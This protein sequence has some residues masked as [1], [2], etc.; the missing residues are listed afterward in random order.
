MLPGAEAP[1][2]SGDGG[3][4]SPPL[5]ELEVGA[6]F[7]KDSVLKNNEPAA[8]S[9]AIE[10]GLGPSGSRIAP[11]TRHSVFFGDSEMAQ[12]MAKFD[13]S[14][15]PLGPVENW[16]QSLKTSV[17]LI[18]NSQHPMWIGWGPERTF[19][20]NDA[21]VSVLSAAKHPWALGRP[22][23]EV[24]A[25]IWDVCGPLA[26][27]VFQK[28]EATFVNDVQLFMRRGEGFLEETF[29]S[30]S[31]SPIRD[32][33]GAVAG[34]FCP[35][36]EVTAKNLNARRLA[37]LSELAG[38]SFVEKTTERA[39]AS[40][41]ATL[42]KNTDDIPFFLIYLIEGGKQAV[43]RES[44]RIAIGSPLAAR[45][46]SLEGENGTTNEWSI[47]EVVRAR[48]PKNVSL[49][50]ISFPFLGLAGQPLT[51]A[52]VLPLISRGDDAPVG[53]L[54][55]GVNPTRKLD[56]DHRTFFNL[57]AGQ[58]A[59][60]IANA[61]ASEQ[62][63]KRL[64]ALAE[65]D[66]AKTVFFNNVSHEFR[67]PLTLMLGPV[68]ELLNHASVLTPEDRQ[69]QM[70]VV[71]R[72]C[73]RLLK[74]VNTLL[75]FSRIEAGRIQASYEPVDLCIF[76]TDLASAFRSAM[77]KAGLSF[78]VQC[79][80]LPQ[81]VFV[82]RDMW[83]KIVF[84][85][86][87]NAFKFTLK[88][89]VTLSLVAEGGE[90]VLRVADTGTGIPE[91]EMGNVFKRFHRVHNVQSR[92]HEGTG[93]GLAMVQDLVKLHGGTISVESKFGKGSTFT[94]RLPFGDKHLP[95]ERVGARERSTL[96]S[97]TSGDV[98]VEEAMRWIP[99]GGPGAD[100][101]KALGFAPVREGKLPRI[102]VADD[103]ADMRDY[104]G[105]LL[106]GR[107]ELEMTPDGSDALTAARRKKPDIII[108]DIMMPRM[109]GFALLNAIRQDSDLKTVPVILLSA[110]AGDEARVEGIQEGA[111]D[112]L[113]KPF[114]GRE[115]V[116]RLETH[117]KLAR[118]RD[119]AQEA[120]KRLNKELEQRVEERT[121]SLRAAIAQM[122]EFSYSVSHDL[123]SPV[124]AMHGYAKV[125]IE[126]YGDKLDSEGKD[127]LQ[128]IVQSSTRMDRLIHD[129]LTYT[130]VARQEIHLERI[131]L[132]RFVRGVIEQFPEFA[133]NRA[134]IVIE[135]KLPEAVGH[136][137]S[138]SQVI[139]NLL[140]NAVKFVAPGV[141]P[142]VRIRA[143]LH[144]N[145]VRLWFEDNGIGIKP[146]YQSRLFGM[147]E[148]IHPEG[149]YQGTGIGL[150]IVRKSMERMNGKAGLESDGVHGSKFWIQM[151]AA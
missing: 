28:G 125:V 62:E 8:M 69:L 109:D 42:A 59:T 76:T 24:W 46:A 72:N 11:A 23:S 95:G 66:R 48:E 44:G 37:T 65:L 39:V 9:R 56:A 142:E 106:H 60:A 120:Q 145:S 150:A 29:Y 82:D 26:E 52:Q 58:L 94:V 143:E 12:L 102:V 124:R 88:G 130:R 118:V 103:N 1:V 133:P 19:L 135:G 149:K 116:A 2:V 137:P 7:A 129:V 50:D 74:L 84:N 64:E 71:H 54:V 104:I 136:E 63:R 113:V 45:T 90:A 18:L 38:N 144:G 127:L 75:D 43:L 10:P 126:D 134:K 121:A 108:S 41:A 36:S 79:G 17:N 112:Y 85:L 100:G 67:T 14:R 105:H 99:E 117:L 31:Y 128:R 122:E 101:E 4:V 151:R 98:F 91:S 80:P 123:R 140:H 3:L 61:R 132:D 16:P 138:L 21:Y 81:S 148:R 5:C 86:L 119:E 15:T 141:M 30:F 110:R 47:R 115:L 114:S 73:L 77:E 78:D 87:S 49:R 146:E 53:V 68:E 6:Q 57:I 147:F 40:A 32:E 33:S 131:S 92:T 93:I 139:S 89:G 20:Y 34:L 51:E 97:G 13:W 25:E 111:D 83:E 107:Y 96:A 55:A 35:S 27:K 22:A 70:R